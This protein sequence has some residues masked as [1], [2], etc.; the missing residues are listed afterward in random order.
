MLIETLFGI[1]KL[2]SLTLAFL[3]IWVCREFMHEHG[4]SQVMLVVKNPSDNA[5]DIRDEGSIPELGRSPGGGQ[6][7]TLHYPCLENAMDRGAWQATVH[8]VA[9][10]QTRLEQLSMHACHV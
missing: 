6:G 5:G 10:N 1:L 7:Y 2:L 3:P 9:M 4:T 8:K